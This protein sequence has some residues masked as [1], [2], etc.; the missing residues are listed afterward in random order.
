MIRWLR[1]RSPRTYA[2]GLCFG[3]ILL[4]ALVPVIMP[5]SVLEGL[6]RA[7]P[8]SLPRPCRSAPNNVDEVLHAPVQSIG[9]GCS[10]LGVSIYPS[11]ELLAVSRKAAR[12]TRLEERPV[13]LFAHLPKAA[14]TTASRVLRRL[15]GNSV[16]P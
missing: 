11:E 10:A 3:C 1:W 6:L 9:E 2:L 15:V 8:S 16:C 7:S 14:G 5:W 4:I 12:P 13:L